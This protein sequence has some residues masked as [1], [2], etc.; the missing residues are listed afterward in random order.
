MR[1]AP[2]TAT[3]HGM[4]TNP[5]GVDDTDHNALFLIERMQRADCT[6]AQIE[7]AVRALRGEPTERR[8]WNRL[9]RPRL[10]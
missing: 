4:D 6:Q 8:H 2:E 5:P 9:L 3:F 10:S 1:A 7:A